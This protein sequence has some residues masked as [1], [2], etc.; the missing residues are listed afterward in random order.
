MTQQIEA[1]AE[2]GRA[3]A[4]VVRVPGET[5][6]VSTHEIV[7]GR[8]RVSTRTEFM[9]DVAR[10]VLESKPIEVTR[11][12][13]GIVVGRAPAV[14]TE[15]S[16]TIIPVLEEVLV[17]EKKLVLNE[18]LHIRRRTFRDEVE[19]P[20]TLRR[21]RVLVERCDDAGHLLNEEDHR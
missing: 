11:V 10:A 12:A 9:D 1:D 18:E 15:G 5:A 7:T 16:I 19:T 3:A 6:A 4:N 8:V 20:V 17:V 14:R 2:S 21:R 13:A